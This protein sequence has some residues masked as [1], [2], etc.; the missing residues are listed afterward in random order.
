[1]T[2]PNTSAG[3]R[4]LSSRLR[5]GPV[6][7]RIVVGHKALMGELG[8]FPTG[9][10]LEMH[11]THASHHVKMGLDQVFPALTGMDIFLFRSPMPHKWPAVAWLETLRHCQ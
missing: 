3:L 11:L 10:L 6:G 2:Q 9:H 5:W 1:M 4:R 8:P 7:L